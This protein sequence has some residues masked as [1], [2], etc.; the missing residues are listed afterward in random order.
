MASSSSRRKNVS[1]VSRESAE[2][3]LCDGT[4]V[5]NPSGN[6]KA[7]A[8]SLAKL[9]LI[10]ATSREF[11]RCAE[12]LD[13]DFPP[14]N[15]NCPG[16]IYLE[17]GLDEAGYDYLC[18]EC[19]RPV[20]PVRYH[21]R[22][23][24]ELQVHVDPAGVGAYVEQALGKLKSPVRRLGDGVFRV[25]EGDVG[26]IV[27]IADCCTDDKYLTRD[28]ASNHPTLYVCVNE[29]AMQDRFLAED[30]L[31]R[32][33]LA[34]VLAGQVDLSARV[35]EL[36]TKGPPRS[37]LNASLPVYAKAH[38]P[39]VVEPVSSAHFDRMF[40]VEVGKKTVRVNGEM[41][42]APQS[43]AR[44]AVFKILWGRF[45][46]AVLDGTPPSEHVPLSIN[47]LAKELEQ[48]DG[49]YRDDLDNLRRAVNRLQSDIEKAVKQKL[50]LPIDREDIIQ[51][52]RWKGADA[53]DYG[54]RINPATVAAR[55]WQALKPKD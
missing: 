40:V 5:P 19:N 25:D 48:L 29:R 54:Y 35:A 11:V 1:S 51:T 50:G 9:G 47:D 20:F 7:A 10:T 39:I 34:D 13:R 52:C 42:V 12:P 28:W 33:S 49:G 26:V 27:C 15:R 8:D 46:Q 45:L 30:W 16:R 36:A 43:G 23:T 37:V 22:R 21:K 24:A 31:E 44:F 53:G 55:P 6:L 32:C 41:V 3:L 4:T 18:P 2:R 38:R 14:R 17:N